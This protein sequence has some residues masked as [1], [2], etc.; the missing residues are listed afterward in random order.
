VKTAQGR[1][2]PATY[3]A[4][5]VGADRL[6][7]VQ[8]LKFDTRGEVPVAVGADHPALTLEVPLTAEQQAALRADLAM[9]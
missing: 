4:R 7:S 6:S 1:R 8:Y 2:V 9:G 3:D 5:Q